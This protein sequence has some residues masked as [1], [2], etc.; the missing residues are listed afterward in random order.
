[1]F[2]TNLTT[3]AYFTFCLIFSFLTYLIVEAPFANI[4]N[5]FIRS[6]RSKD[7]VPTDTTHYQSQSAKAY[8]RAKNKG[9]QQNKKGKD[10]E[11]DKSTNIQEDDGEDYQDQ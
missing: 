3:L 11:K 9:S 2:E 7:I 6:K 5:D 8:L 10:L 1:M 4:L